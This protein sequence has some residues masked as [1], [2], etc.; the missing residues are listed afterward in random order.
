MTKFKGNFVLK[1]GRFGIIKAK[2]KVFDGL[3]RNIF[4]DL[5]SGEVANVT[6]EAMGRVRHLKG[7]EKIFGLVY[8]VA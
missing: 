7:T 1:C 5:A 6:A 2:E 8:F 4:I 3:M